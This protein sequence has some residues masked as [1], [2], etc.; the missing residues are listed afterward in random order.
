MRVSE[1]ERK[2]IKQNAKKIFGKDTRVYLFGSR[3][4]DKLKGGDIDLYIISER[5][6]NLFEKKI[7][8]VTDVEMKIGI[9]KIDVV[10]AKN[11]NRDIEISALKYGIQL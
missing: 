10:I 7:E 11:K 4:N 1:F 2:V 3:V 9:Q 5:K 8:F 6:D